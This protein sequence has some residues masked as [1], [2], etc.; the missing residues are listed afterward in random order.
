VTAV[1]QYLQILK[2]NHLKVTPQRLSILKYLDT[3]H[4]HPTV[5]EIYNVLKKKNPSLSKTTVY[6]TLEILKNHHIIH[7][8]SITG[9]EQR[10][11]LRKEI[12]HHFLCR[13]CGTIQDIDLKCPNI[14]QIQ[15]LGYQIE[16]MHGYFKGL[17]PDCQKNKGGL[18]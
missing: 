1:D 18:Q 13:T 8:I 10:Y 11:D 7:A 5:E 17:C 4:T 15:N 16:E 9:H 6:N 2:D 12:H 14:K 3:H